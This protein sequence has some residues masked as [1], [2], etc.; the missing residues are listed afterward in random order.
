MYIIKSVL[1]DLWNKSWLRLSFISLLLTF[2]WKTDGSRIAPR[3]PFG[4]KWECRPIKLDFCK[5]IGYNQT[6]VMT[7]TT[8][9]PFTLKNSQEES[10]AELTHYQLS[11]IHI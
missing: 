5:D 4:P 9:N 11:L 3:K 7:S 6:I 10:H 1:L 8:P 2:V